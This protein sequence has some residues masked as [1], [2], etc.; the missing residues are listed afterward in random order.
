M[1]GQEIVAGLRASARVTQSSRPSF[2]T[3]G[4]TRCTRR[5]ASTSGTV[6]MS[7]TQGGRA[8]Q[9]RGR[10]STESPLGGRAKRVGGRFILAP[11]SPGGE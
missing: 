8:M 11:N 2:V 1:A 5:R 7:N 3:L 4:G 10:P 9:W 6:S